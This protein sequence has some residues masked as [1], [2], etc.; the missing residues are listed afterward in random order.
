MFKDAALLNMNKMKG[1]VRSVCGYELL[2]P[3]TPKYE[4]SRNR[5]QA[6]LLSAGQECCVEIPQLQGI[7]HISLINISRS[8]LAWSAHRFIAETHPAELHRESFSHKE[9]N[10]L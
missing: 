6:I 2:A 9:G 10:A 3:R 7:G 5:D 8:H 1:K 4:H